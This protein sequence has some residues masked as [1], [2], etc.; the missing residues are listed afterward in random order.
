[1]SYST[2]I[3][4]G[5]VFGAAVFLIGYYVLS[6]RKTPV[7]TGYEGMIGS[8][9]IVIS[10]DESKGDGRIQTRGELW[11]FRLKDGK[12]KISVGDEVTIKSADG[13]TF[14]VVKE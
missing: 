9:A 3:M 10:Y 7:Q 14:I 4:V 8:K 11:H 13:M 1:M 5:V 2:L 12:Q 6:V